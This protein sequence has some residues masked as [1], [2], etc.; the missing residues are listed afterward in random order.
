MNID[1]I[2]SY[3]ALRQI[4]MEDGYSNLA[5]NEAIEN[6][7]GCSHGFVRY[8]VKGVV[9]NTAKLDYYISQL[10]KNG[11]KGMKKRT[12][13]LLRMGVY[14]LSEMDDMPDHAAVS[15]MV[16]LTK[17]VAKGND[18]F[19]NAILRAYIRSRETIREPQD[20]YT[21]YSISKPI[22]DLL[23]KQYGKE[24]GVK[25][26]ESFNNPVPVT[27]R[28]NSL[29]QTR[30]ELLSLLKEISIDAEI[31]DETRNGIVVNSGSV[32]GNDLYR[33]GNYTVQGI[34]SQQAIEA[35]AP[36]AGSKVLDMCAAPG[37]KSTAMAEIMGNRGEI[38]S[39][40]I[41]EHRVE[42]IRNSAERLGIDIIKP[43]VLDGTV[44]REEYDSY[45]D[46]VL[47]DVPCS[48]LGTIHSKPE[49][50]LNKAADFG[51]LTEIQSCILANAYRY[52]R[53]GGRIMY[54]TCTINKDENEGV[55]DAFLKCHPECNLVEKMAILPYNKNGFFY[56]IIEKSV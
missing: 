48:G 21:K 4:Y 55:L 20:I 19:V 32:V 11:L 25:I 54:S 7:A 34:S 3:E 36:K 40:D 47:A 38:I 28:N 53:P 1:L 8:V 56:S 14:I 30:D 5:I 46:Y 12:L 22:A 26:I 6:N 17:K 9:R 49:I 37:G 44:Y 51:Q 27:L 35:F 13:V 16:E 41:H 52:T 39:C 43:A 31:S 15:Q 10:S 24:E 23:I 45:F 29:K 42:L 18:R 2:A 33:G 50:K